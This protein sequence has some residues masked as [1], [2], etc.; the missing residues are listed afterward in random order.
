MRELEDALIAEEGAL[1]AA[2]SVLAE[3]DAALAL[4]SVAGDFGFVRP[5]VSKQSLTLPQSCSLTHGTGPRGNCLLTSGKSHTNHDMHPLPRSRSVPLG[6]CKGFILNNALNGVQRS[7]LSRAR[8]SFVPSQVTHGGNR[9]RLTA[10]AVLSRR[11]SPPLEMF[12]MRFCPVS[13][14]RWWRIT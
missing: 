3:L 1:H 2:A 10:L 11:I 8:K 12:L 7:I 14:S 9:H 5:E 4:A 13:Y 6:F